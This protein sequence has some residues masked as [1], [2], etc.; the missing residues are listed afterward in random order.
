M[1]FSSSSKD[2][3]YE[4]SVSS[5]T[6]V[7]LVDDS[8]VYWGKAFKS[9]NESKLR[10]NVGRRIGDYLESH[11]PDFREFDGVVV[12]HPKQLRV[13]TLKDSV[14]QVLEEYTVLME[15][16]GEWNA[17]YGPISQPI[18]GHA[19]PRQKIFWTT[20]E[21]IGG[22][23][24]DIGGSDSGET[25]GWTEGCADCCSN[26][27]QEEF[28]LSGDTVF[29]RGS[30]WVEEEGNW[31]YLDVVRY[32][33]DAAAMADGFPAAGYYAFGY[34]GGTDIVDP[35]SLF[36]FGNGGDGIEGGME[37]AV[38]ISYYTE[39]SYRLSASRLVFPNASEFRIE[40]NEMQGT[41]GSENLQYINADSAEIVGIYA[42]WTNDVVTATTPTN[43]KVICFPNARLGTIRGW[44]SYVVNPYRNKLRFEKVD[45]PNARDLFV[46]LNRSRTVECF[47]APYAKNGMIALD[48]NPLSSITLP[49]IAYDGGDNNL[50]VVLS[51]CTGLTY[52]YFGPAVKG[53]PDGGHQGGNYYISFYKCTSLPSFENDY[54]VEAGSFGGSAGGAENP[55]EP[56]RSDSGGW[57]RT[58]VFEKCSSLE[59]VR[60]SALKFLGGQCFKDCPNLTAVTAPNVEEIGDFA[61]YG[62]SG[63]TDVYFPKLKKISCSPVFAY[64]RAFTSLTLYNEEFVANNNFWAVSDVNWVS[65]PLFYGCENLTT[66]NFPNLREF[67][68]IGGEDKYFS[69]ASITHLTFGALERLENTHLPATLTY[70]KLPA[71]LRKLKIFSIYYCPSLTEIDFDGTYQQFKGITLLPPLN[72]AAYGFESKSWTIHCLDRDGTLSARVVYSQGYGDHWEITFN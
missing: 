62:C 25:S 70:L 58:G 21:E 59:Y 43:L 37:G 11:M 19:D 38:R 24:I 35:N 69:G 44:F 7:I 30:L 45:F 61:F 20:V 67:Y 54:I 42:D 26:I 10:V 65:K 51:N 18:N 46:N 15:W 17:Y 72:W 64:C 39:G 22:S 16:T 71:T 12:P 9:P 28:D 34:T 49:S 47:S 3:Y 53:T 4:S 2:F 5:L 57:I 60:L 13:F 31:P 41:L 33:T 48:S 52:A 29:S 36:P 27:P 68:E 63:L 14:G 50:R 55:S 6:Y 56:G 40:F 32:K 8:P 1:I 23:S 66:V